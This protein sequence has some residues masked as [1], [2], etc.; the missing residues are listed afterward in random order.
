MARGGPVE[1]PS[2]GRYFDC[3]DLGK[4]TAAATASGADGGIARERLTRSIGGSQTDSGG[5]KA[6]RPQLR[7]GKRL[8]D[9][10]ILKASA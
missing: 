2:R 9:L 5:A 10:L 4:R 7:P 1:A 6:S 8:D 3:P